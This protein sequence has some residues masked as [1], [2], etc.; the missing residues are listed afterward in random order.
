MKKLETGVIC[1]LAISMLTGCSSSGELIKSYSNTAL[2]TKSLIIHTD[3]DDN[4]DFFAKDLVVFP[5]SSTVNPAKSD[6]DA[7]ETTEEETKTADETETDEAD[8]TDETKS[9]DETEESLSENDSDREETGIDAKTGLLA[10]MDSL[11]DVYAKDIYTRVYPASLTKIMTALITL[12]NANFSDKVTFTEDMVENEYA[13]KLCGFEVG[14]ELTVEQLFNALLIYSGNDAANALAVHV[15]GSIEAFTALMNKEAKRL[16]CVDTNFVNAGGL[17]DNNYYTSAYDMYLI[18]NECLKHDEFAETIRHSSYKATYTDAGGETVYAT[19]TTTN[20]YFLDAYDYPES[21][22][23]LGGKTGT[24]NE[25]G[26][27]LIL[28]DVDK[29]ENGYISVILGASG[30]EELYSEMNILLNKIPK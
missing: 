12:E 14:D 30:S 28:Y 7:A 3:T 19:Y 2:N 8:E 5:K 9:A 23:V 11:S 6:E 1:L 27:C 4:H 29:K 22:R 26:S 24:T 13:A 10:G 16:G 17:H 15:A 20:Q 21:V 25:A 18:F